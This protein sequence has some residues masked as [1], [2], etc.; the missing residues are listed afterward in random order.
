MRKNF[1]L[2]QNM[3]ISHENNYTG[4][5]ISNFE[6]NFEKLSEVYKLHRKSQVKD[7]IKKHDSLIDY[8]HVITPII[9]NHFPNHLKCLTFC[10]DPEFSRLNDIVVYITCKESS[11]DSNWQKLDKLQ[12]ELFEIENFSRK[13]K[14]L[15]SVDLWL[16]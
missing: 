14:G 9:E 2:I 1:S 12:R 3:Q 10:K 5:N 8:I 6:N 11:F 16:V 4:L 7:F 15:I 13:T